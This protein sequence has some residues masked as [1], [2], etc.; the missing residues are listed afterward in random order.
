MPKIIGES[1]A[2]HRNLT[3]HRLFD[4]LGSLL[5]EQSFDTITMSAIAAR[6]GIGRTAVYNHFQDKEVLLLAYMNEATKEFA[7][8]LGEL[9]ATEPDPISRLRSYVSVHLEMTDRF[10][11]AFRL[12]LHD[13]MSKENSGHLHEHAETVGRV[14]FT[15]LVDAMKSGAIPRQDPRILV[16][17][18]HSCLSGQ[19]LP[20][21]PDQRAARNSQVQTFILRAVGVPPSRL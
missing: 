4:A 16:S 13:Q 21:T 2:D 11:F 18:I 1:L 17:L 14:L 7:R 5:S 3:R 12:H 20:R 6:A 8:Q 15:I 19:H 9:I 10:H